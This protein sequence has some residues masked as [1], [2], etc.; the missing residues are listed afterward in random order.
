[1]E[2]RFGHE[3]GNVQIHDDSLAHQS[4][5]EINALAYTHG[6]H[7]AFKEG[8][9][10]PHSPSGKQLLA[11]EL[12]HVV[13]SANHV[14]RKE[15]SKS[16]EVFIQNT[17]LGGLSVGNFD[18]HF[19]NC[20]ILVWVWLKFQFTKDI[21]STEQADFK[22]RFVNAIHKVWGHP[23]YSL[24]A[25]SG[26]PCGTIPIEVHT[27]ENTNKYYHKLVDVERQSDSDRRPKVISD[28][29][30]NFD[31]R[32]ETFAHE[33]GHVLG[34][35]DEYDGGFFENIMFWHKNQN[36]PWALMSQDWQK[37]P[38]AQQMQ[39]SRS[40]QLRP[41]Y[42]EHYRKEVQKHSRKGCEYKISS[43]RPPV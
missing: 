4:A 36:D 25:T 10:Q 41:R 18:F 24:T 43:P 14:R 29:N 16:N 7:I 28:I 9:Y 11:H 33:F 17:E 35:Y 19:R 6:N 40:T 42:F 15:D 8:Q 37:V 31:S 30:I 5:K 21:N 32:D 26:C 2:S 20:G 1:M 13:Q 38:P 23:G 12:A 27:E 39:V 34:L 22:K 3:F